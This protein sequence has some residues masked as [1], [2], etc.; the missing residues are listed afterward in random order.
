MEDKHAESFSVLS[1]NLPEFQ[2]TRDVESCVVAKT[3]LLQRAQ[4]MA[5][6]PNFLDEIGERSFAVSPPPL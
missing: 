5:L 2:Q 4:Q 3:V 1:G 6:P